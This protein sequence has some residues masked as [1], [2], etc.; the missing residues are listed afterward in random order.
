MDLTMSRARKIEFVVGCAA[1]FLVALRPIGSDQSGSQSVSG[2]TVVSVRRG[3]CPIGRCPEYVLHILSNGRVLW[4]GLANV[5]AMG[6]RNGELTKEQAVEI[7]TML[8]E[9]NWYELENSYTMLATDLPFLELSLSS[10]QGDKL[11]HSSCLGELE[12]RKAQASGTRV[13]GA[14]NLEMCMKLEVVAEV[15]ESL[16]PVRDWL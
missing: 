13:F 12:L 14:E 5:T 6:P 2:G 3:A 7:V 16:P 9:A 1:L 15:I 8:Y 4:W 11:V 10:Q